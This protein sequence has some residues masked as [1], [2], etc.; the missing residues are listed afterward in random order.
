MSTTV[1]YKGQTLTT[2]DNETKVLETAGTW[3][4]DDITIV[5]VSSGGGGTTR[6]IVLYDNSATIT[7]DPDVNY[8]WINNQPETINV[9]D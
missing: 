6:Y 2:A 1:S 5:D 8:I 3:L 7:Q 4:E 9:G